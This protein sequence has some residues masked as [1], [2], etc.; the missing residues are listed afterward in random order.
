M[1]Y[2]TIVFAVVYLVVYPGFG[3]YAG[4]SAWTSSG[5][6]KTE[7]ALAESRYGPTFNRYLGQGLEVVAAD[8]EAR[9]IGQRLFLTY[10][11]QCHGS[12][13]GGGIG[14]PNLR[15]KDWLYGGEPEAIKA[16]IMEGRNGVMPALSSA[17]GGVEGATQ[18]AHYVMSLSGRPHDTIKAAFGKDKFVVCAACHGSDGK[19][20]K[21]LGAPNLTDDIWLHGS[22]QEAIVETILMGRKSSMPPHKDFLGEAKAH[23]LAAYI[24]SLSVES[25]VAPAQK[26][27]GDA[28]KS[29]PKK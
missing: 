9:A 29:E 28:Q 2:V 17:V 27:Y 20:S 13:A 8:S 25:G 26:A 19:G 12:D 7:T 22:S 15:D 5:Q 23:V 11:A 1:F 24:Y 21:A 4:V 3:S 14:F 16:S 18:V 6:Y 10:C